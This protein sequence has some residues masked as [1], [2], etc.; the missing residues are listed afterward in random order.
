MEPL[1]PINLQ[2]KT[3][4]D[5]ETSE[6][7]LVIVMNIYFWKLLRAQGSGVHNA[8]FTVGSQ[9][10]FYIPLFITEQVTRYR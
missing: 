7:Y 2:P 1:F 10:L 4:R 8:G 5:I 9:P 6:I 3:N